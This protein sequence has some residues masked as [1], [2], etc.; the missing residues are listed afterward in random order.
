MARTSGHRASHTSLVA[1]M[2]AYSDD[3]KSM[4]NSKPI[5][6]VDKNLAKEAN[7]TRHIEKYNEQAA[8][9]KAIQERKDDVILVGGAEYEHYCNVPAHLQVDFTK[10]KHYLKELWDNFWSCVKGIPKI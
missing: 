7:L 9:W 6:I 3:F 5:V 1:R 8:K 10:N 4:K 2:G